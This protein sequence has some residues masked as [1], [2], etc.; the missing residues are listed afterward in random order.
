VSKERV[1]AFVNE[2]VDSCPNFGENE[3]VPLSDILTKLEQAQSRYGLLDLLHKCE[4]D[5]YDKLHDIL[6]QWTVGMAMIV[7]DEITTRLKLIGECVPPA[8]L[9]DF[10]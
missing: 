7:L 8:R 3:I 6:R 4:P 10:I 5:D 9:L 1:T 2:V